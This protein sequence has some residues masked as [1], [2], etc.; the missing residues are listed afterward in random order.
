[1]FIYQTTRPENLSISLANGTP[2]LT[3]TFSLNMI[4]TAMIVVRLIVHRRNARRAISIADSAGG[5]YT[6]II[7]IIIESYGISAIS[8]LLYIG[9]W[10]ANSFIQY[11]FLQILV[12]AEV[13]AV[14]DVFRP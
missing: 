14:F 12:Q 4:L 7:T 2:Y 1:M 10:A 9:A 11:V 5:L 3:V 13:C 6:T 8:S